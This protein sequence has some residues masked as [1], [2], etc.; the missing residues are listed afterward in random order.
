MREWFAGVVRWRYAEGPPT[1]IIHALL[2]LVKPAHK[3]IRATPTAAKK[4]QLQNQRLTPTVE[5]NIYCS[6]TATPPPAH[7]LLRT[8]C[9]G[10]KIFIT[11]KPQRP[12][13]LH[14]AI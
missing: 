4:D 6:Q 11:H 14:K 7:W 12:L 1:N 5:I 9:G 3:I 13:P 2:L 8:R 10:R